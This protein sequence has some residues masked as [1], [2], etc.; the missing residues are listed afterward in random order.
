MLVLQKR[1]PGQVV[2]Q[3]DATAVREA[4]NIDIQIG[5]RPDNACKVIETHGIGII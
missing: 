1:D 5:Q 4:K 2:R 3:Y